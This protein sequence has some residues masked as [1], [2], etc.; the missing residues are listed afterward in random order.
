MKTRTLLLCFTASFI[1]AYAAIQDESIE[2]QCLTLITV[3]YDPIKNVTI[4]SYRTRT[5]DNFDSKIITRTLR[6][7]GNQTHLL[8]PETMINLTWIRKQYL[9]TTTKTLIEAREVYPTV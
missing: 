9:L 1:V 5:Q 6:F 7:E 8:E 4:C 2:R 3:R